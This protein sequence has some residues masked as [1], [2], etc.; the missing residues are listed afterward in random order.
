MQGLRG[1]AKRD[2]GDTWRACI[3]FAKAHLGLTD[4]S[5]RDF[6]VC[7]RLNQCNDAGII[8]QFSDLQQRDRWIIGVPGL[9]NSDKRISIS[10]DLPPFVRPLK[11]ELFEKQRALRLEVTANAHIRYLR[12]WPCVQ[13][14]YGQ[15]K[16]PIRPNSESRTIVQSFLWASPLYVPPRNG[17]H[18]GDLKHDYYKYLC[19]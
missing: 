12:Q 8:A 17:N 16:D 3:E 5:K 10:P 6:A 13:T 19:Y 7:H 9:K 15:D 11:K 1:D 14:A 2:E 18:L 4:A